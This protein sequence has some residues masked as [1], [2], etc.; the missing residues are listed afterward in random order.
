MPIKGKHNYHSQY[1]TKIQQIAKMDETEMIKYYNH[2]RAVMGQ[3]LRHFERKGYADSSDWYQRNKDVFVSKGQ[4]LSRHVRAQALIS[5]E[6]QLNRAD[7]TTTG[8]EKTREKILRTLHRKGSDKYRPFAYVNEDNLDKWGDFMEALRDMTGGK[9]TYYDPEELE[10][11]WNKYDKYGAES[12]AFQDA[13]DAFTHHPATAI[14]QDKE[15]EP[16]EY[17]S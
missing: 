11:L 10:E 4:E 17:N 14:I 12:D 5:L 16:N 7:S 6:T 9:M 1:D 15:F 8:Y 3:R 2:L 13:F